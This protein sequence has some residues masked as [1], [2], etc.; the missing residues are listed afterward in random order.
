MFTSGQIP[1]QGYP[2]PSY[3]R[4]PY[5]EDRE[6]EN[7]R[8]DTKILHEVEILKVKRE[9]AAAK[10]TKLVAKKRLRATLAKE[11]AKKKGKRL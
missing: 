5:S 2:T 11:K 3:R 8:Q 9:E 4:I 7:I 1:I 6:I 10:G